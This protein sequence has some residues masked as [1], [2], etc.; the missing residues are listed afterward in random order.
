MRTTRLAILALSSLAAA[1][2][3]GH[4]GGG[5]AGAPASSGAGG[6]SAN[7]GG[8]SG[9][10]VAAGPVTAA[11]DYVALVEDGLEGAVAPL[12]AGHAAAGRNVVAVPLSAV[13]A[14]GRDRAEEIR[15]WLV[16][17]CDD[18]KTR[19]LLLVGGPTAIPFRTCQV[20]PTTRPV[21]C[22]LYYGNLTGN[23][24]KDGNGVYGEL[25]SDAP[26]FDAELHV[27]RIPYDD[28]A[29]VATAVTAIERARTG[30]GA[31]Q[32]ACLIVGAEIKV[33]GDAPFACE[34][35]RTQYVEPD[36]WTVTTAYSAASPI[37]GD[38]ALGQ[39]TLL[40]TLGAAPE[41][42]VLCISH[43]DASGLFSNDPAGWLQF[44]AAADL[45][46]FPKDRPPVLVAG[47]CDAGVPSGGAGLGESCLRQGLAGFV[48]A[49][50][51]VDPLSGGGAGLQAEVNIARFI[52]GGRSLGDAL[53]ATVA[54]YAAAGLAAATDQ[55]GREEVYVEA[56]SAILYGDPALRLG[57]KAP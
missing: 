7:T 29:D 39:G 49:T 17:Q 21:V 34:A 41:A 28:P 45:A 27:G 35:I 14:S 22:D 13:Q 24:D 47:A 6:T 48:G 53:A 46:S 32:N 38:L 57:P 3:G 23:W 52:A 5:S 1:G 20:G 51:T 8:Q 36:G 44:L 55:A 37:P 19:D 30:G 16:A 50:T 42:F 18:G 15:N 9:G 31:W 10:T 11:T 33:P 43:G 54:D 56:M 26:G 12:L 4:G 25:A 2:C 40:Q